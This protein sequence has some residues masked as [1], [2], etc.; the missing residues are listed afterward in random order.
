MVYAIVKD[1]VV[2]NTI[3]APENWSEGI[4]VVFGS[5]SVGDIYDPN[6]HT[7][8]P[9]PQPVLPEA[10][11]QAALTDAIQRHLDK[12]AQERLYDGILS[13][14]TYAGDPDPILNA[15]G[16]AGKIFRSACWKKSSEIMANVKAGFRT[17]PTVSQL[18]SELPEFTWPD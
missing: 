17:I 13:L 12:V 4:P 5:I 9:A 1:N 8:S 7:F 11:V 6:T 16:M 15:E 10:T 2:V 3:E 18:I 14:C